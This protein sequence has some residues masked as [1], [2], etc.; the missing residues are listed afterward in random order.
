MLMSIF[1]LL[2][3]NSSCSC[4]QD[5]SVYEL[6]MDI[7][8]F[9]SLNFSTES[10]ASCADFLFLSQ[11]ASIDLIQVDSIGFYLGYCHEV[12]WCG[13]FEGS[14]FEN[15]FDSVSYSSSCSEKYSSCSGWSL[16]INKSSW[17]CSSPYSLS[18]KNFS[19]C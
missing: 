8:F 3:S 14:F 11:F 1:F 7:S 18:S 12:F 4:L 9:C 2:Q 15:Q 17:S 5:L 10:F 19:G 6:T 13:K 16:A